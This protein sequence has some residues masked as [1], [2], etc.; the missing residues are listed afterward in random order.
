ME[1]IVTERA[2]SMLNGIGTEIPSATTKNGYEKIN[3]ISACNF[4]EIGILVELFLFL[5]LPEL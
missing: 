2:Y 3:Q 5:S 4:I 1:I